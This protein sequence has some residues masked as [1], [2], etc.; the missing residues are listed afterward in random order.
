MTPTKGLNSAPQPVSKASL[1][2]RVVLVMQGG[3]APG[4]YQAGAYQAVHEAGIEPDWV[5]G[6]SIGAINGA[7]ITGNEIVDRV[8]RLE[9][10]WGQL[11][12][13]LPEPWSQ[14]AP[15]LV[16]VP[17]FY[18]VNPA[19]A[20]GADA[21]VGIEQ[22]AMYLVDPLKKLLPEIVDFN[23]VNSGKTRFTLGLTTVQTGR[24]RYFDN[25]QERIGPEHVLGSSALPPCFPAVLIDRDYYWDGGVLGRVLRMAPEKHEAFAAAVGVD[26]QRARITIFILTSV[27]LGFIGGFYA[28]QYRG[29]AYSIFDFQ[30]VLLGL[31]MITIGGIGRAEGAVLGTFVVI[32]L[33]DVLLF[34]AAMLSVVLF[35]NN[36]YFGIRRQF[37]AWRAKKRGEWRST[38]TEKGGEA[39]PE[40]ATEYSDKDALY[41][42]RFDKMQRDYLKDLI[43]PEIIEEHRRQPLGQ[44]S[45]ALER[46]LL[47]FRRAKMEDKYALH[48]GGGAGSYK[49]IA[50]S[51]VRGVSPRLVDDREF[52]TLDEAY[53]A[54]FM[55]RVHD[56]LES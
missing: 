29:V 5:I 49:I 37:N 51:G 4:S 13:R 19:L 35:L 41:F 30:T 1:P 2:G 3:G 50:F 20:W 32:F 48:R 43:T 38:R 16:G 45:E 46:V 25:Q 8:R 36:G 21:R 26:Y 18:Q 33:R 39:L 53:H 27:A 52:T 10:F 15:L 7:I 54:V 56:L 14:L 42:R 24:M 22:A 31:A 40:E 23:L 9:E 17:G 47:Y 55:R 6:T 34:G 28:A 12:T 44:H 11:D